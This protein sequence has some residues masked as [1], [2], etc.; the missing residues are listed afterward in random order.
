MDIYYLKVNFGNIKVVFVP[1][2]IDLLE[3]IQNFVHLDNYKAY[4]NV[5]V[6]DTSLNSS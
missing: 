4:D 5:V 2:D 3:V 6:V 1:I